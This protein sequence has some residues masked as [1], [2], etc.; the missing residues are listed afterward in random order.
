MRK[1]I[2]TAVLLAALVVPPALAAGESPTAAIQ[3]TVDKIVAYL[4]GPTLKAKAKD[5]AEDR[6][7][8]LWELIDERFASQLMT[9]KVLARHWKELSGEQQ[10]EMVSLFSDLL[11]RSYVSK[12]EAYSGQK[13]V[14]L[15]QRID[16]E[17][18]EVDSTVSHRDEEISLNY[19]LKFIDGQWM[20]YDVI[21]DGVSLVANYR[22]QF[23]AIITKD[24]YQALV[25]RLK[26]RWAEVKALEEN[27]GTGE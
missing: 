3:G 2:L 9:R 6:Q 20:V 27:G 15:D 21:I 23:A 4:S 1:L 18:A 7:A 24:G 5:K 26:K 17:F 14:Y 13:V 11:K 19:R 22:R 25:E 12:L 16:G 8:K 10:A